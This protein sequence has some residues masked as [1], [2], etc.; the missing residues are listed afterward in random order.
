M[1]ISELIEILEEI[2]NEYGDLEVQGK[3][4]PG[5][6]GS[7]LEKDDNFLVKDDILFLGW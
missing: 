2:Q 5:E 4:H 6:E 1:K 7:A 3:G